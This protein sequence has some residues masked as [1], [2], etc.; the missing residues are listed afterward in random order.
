MGGCGGG[1]IVDVL[2]TSKWWWWFNDGGGEGV[3]VDNGEIK[4]KNVF[5]FFL[6]KM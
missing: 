6:S 4:K 1:I 3:S 2:K 5:K